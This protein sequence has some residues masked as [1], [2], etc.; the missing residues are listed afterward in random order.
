MKVI[1]FKNKYLIIFLVI[2]LYPINAQKQDLTELKNRILISY[3]LDTF[4]SGFQPWHQLSLEYERKYN[5]GSIIPRVNLS[6]RFNKTG[7]QVES[8]SYILFSS[9]TYVYFNAGLSNN[10]IFPEHRLGTE[11]YQILPSNF[12]FSLGLRY[13]SFKNEDVR[14]FTGSFSKYL[15]NYL[16]SIRPF[17]VP[18]S[19]GTKN[20]FIFSARKYFDDKYHFL[21]FRAG[22][23]NFSSQALITGE[24]K[25]TN[26][27]LLNVDYNFYVFEK[28]IL[29]FGFTFEGQENLSDQLLKKYSLNLMITNLF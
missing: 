19:D 21:T 23:G 12:E 11:V 22:L 9:T 20:T 29:G 25:R 10:E 18:Q 15:G 7:F 27:Y 6:E 24:F 16:F 1:N 28:K 14:I 4:S 3:N 2:T 13:L 8:D 5:F 17:I 26:T